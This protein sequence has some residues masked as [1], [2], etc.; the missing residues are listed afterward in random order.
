MSGW[1]VPISRV[2]C[3]YLV[4]ACLLLFSG[5]PFA[6]SQVVSSSRDLIRNQ[7]TDC[8]EDITLGL[9]CYQTSDN[10]LYMGN[11]TTAV[12]IG[13]GTGGADGLEAQR[14]VANGRFITGAET[15]ATAVTGCDN[16]GGVG[17]TSL[18]TWNDYCGAGG[19]VREYRN[20]TGDLLANNFIVPDTR[21]GTIQ[22]GDGAGG[23]ADCWQIGNNGT[24]TGTGEGG[25]LAGITSITATGTISTT[26]ELRGKCTTTIPGV[27]TYTLL[28]TDCVV[29]NNDSDALEVDL[30][31]DPTGKTFCFEAHSTGTITLDPNSTDQFIV[32][33]LS[34]A[35]GEAIILAS[36]IGNNVCIHGIS[37]TQWFVYL[38]TGSVTEET[39]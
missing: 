7:K 38:G 35:A 33:G 36:A 2:V 17:C 1:T 30:V 26:G 31:A 14:A 19:C 24:I 27:D 21:T 10:M 37:T 4:L 11:G 25:A 20:T 8:T 34:P 6:H 39:P 9:L 18:A 13:T 3:K 32:N 16:N 22:C 29:A 5:L 12:A 28:E 23:L 15:L